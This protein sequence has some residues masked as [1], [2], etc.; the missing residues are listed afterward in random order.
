MCCLAD[1]IILGA[2]SL[3]IELSADG[4]VVDAFSG[5]LL[6]GQMGVRPRLQSGA[7]VRDL[8]AIGQKLG[9]CG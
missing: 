1:C 5:Y 8:P 3:V 6:G 9:R 2:S 7:H 4:T